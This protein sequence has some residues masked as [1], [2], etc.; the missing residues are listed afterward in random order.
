MAKRRN[1]EEEYDE[2]KNSLSNKRDFH[3]LLLLESI[4]AA[5]E[6]QYLKSAMLS[7]SFIESYFLPASILHIASVNKLKIE[8]KVISEFS[9]EQKIRYYYLLSFDEELYKKINEGKNLRNTLVHKAYASGSMKQMEA[10]IE[11]SARFNTT[12]ILPLIIK[13]LSNDKQFPSLQQKKRKGRAVLIE[14]NMLIKKRL[15]TKKD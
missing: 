8:Q 3:F 7:W 10:I 14:R 6:A 1:Y 2:L 11:R 13:R 5:Q 9:V 15:F 12:E 4:E